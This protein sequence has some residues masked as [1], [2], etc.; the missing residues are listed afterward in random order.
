MELDREI[1]VHVAKLA[2]V[3]LSD[4]EIELF[5]RQLSDILAHF[6]VLQRVDT[7]GVEPTAH[8]LPLR[9]VMADDE[10]RASMDRDTVLELAPNVEE[11]YVRV[12]AV[13]E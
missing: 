13:L 1:V 7:Q 12:R 11:G 3:A 10:S 4:E 6:D 8:T 2:R 9:N 5:S